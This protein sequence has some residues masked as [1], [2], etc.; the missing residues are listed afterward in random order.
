MRN[1]LPRNRPPTCGPGGIVFARA[2]VVFPTSPWCDCNEKTQ[3]G[4]AALHTL[5]K[6]RS[7]ESFLTS[8]VSKGANVRQGKGEAIRILIA[9]GAERKSPILKA[10]PAAIPV[11][12]RLG[13]GILHKIES[14][15][16]AYVDGRTQA[17]FTRTAIAGQSTEL[18]KLVRTRN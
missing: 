4:A 6:D 12:C 13:G 15:I 11:V 17:A 3:P 9:H 7:K 16:K 14:R 18:I 8:Q 1:P 10:G 5:R 2:A